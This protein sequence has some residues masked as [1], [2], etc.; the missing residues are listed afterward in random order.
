M[1]SFYGILFLLTF[2]GFF[3]RILF[4]EQTIFNSDEAYLTIYA[5]KAARFWELESWRDFPLTGLRTSF[6]FR[7][8][9]LLIY[10]MAPCFAL[11]SDPRFAMLFV[12]LLGS[13]AVLFAGIATRMLYCPKSGLVVALLVAL[14][15]NAVQHS[16]QLWGHD[17]QIFCSALVFWGVALALREQRQRGLCVS[18]AA[19]ISAM[20]F[21]LSG[22]FL[23]LL[24]L[25]TLLLLPKRK[26]WKSLLFV[27]GILLFVYA[28]WL[29]DEA[30][31]NRPGLPSEE[32]FESLRIMSSILMGTGERTPVE[33][34]VLPSL[35]WFAVLVDGFR[36]DIVGTY[37]HDTFYQNPVL[38]LLI[39]GFQVLMGILM[40][41]GLVLM[42]LQRNNPMATVERLLILQSLVPLLLFQFLPISSVPLYML[43]AFLPGCIAVVRMLGWCSEFHHSSLPESFGKMVAVGLLCCILFGSLIYAFRTHHVRRNADFTQS[44]PTVFESKFRAI[45]LIQTV[46]EQVENLP[47]GSYTILQNGRTAD[48][49]V[50]VWIPALYSS[51]T[52]S[53]TFPYHP[54]APSAFLILDNETNLHPELEDILQ[55]KDY[56]PL[57]TL[58]VYR[59]FPGE[60]HRWK[61]LTMQ[62]PSS[63]T[64]G[65]PSSVPH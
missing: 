1:T 56:T 9:P 49:G 32:R 63:R 16:R 10:L 19:A 6:G 51:I 11:S 14:L 21:H 3:L 48:A 22:V 17:L 38:L 46:T 28:P 5:S 43:P 39:G 30:G 2:V 50:D 15:P 44:L 55:R 31:W 7:N 36:L 58:R 45:L 23:L 24:P 20:A 26:A 65:T 47:P 42:A 29:V 41:S 12:I 61:E 13:A 34:P 27:I 62:F 54:E 33:T 25:G 8:P 59:F 37:Y 18:F 4:W 60:L 64:D 52:Q 40:V 57:K 53:K 35:G